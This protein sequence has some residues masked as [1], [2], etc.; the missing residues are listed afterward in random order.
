[1]ILV[2][3]TAAQAPAQNPPYTWSP[4][5][6]PLANTVNGVTYFY[7]PAIN[8]WTVATGG[9][10]AVTT[11]GLGLTITGAFTKVAIPIQSPGPAAGGG[12][13]Q[14]VP[15]SLYWDNTLGELFIYYDDGTTAQWV[16]TTG[17]GT[18]PIPPGLGISQTSGFTKISVPI[19]SPGP[20]AGTGAN[21]AEPGALYWDDSLGEL[22]IYYDDGTTAQWVSTTGGSSV[23]SAGYGM[24]LESN[25]YKPAIPALSA[26][27]TTGTAP[28]EAPDGSMY[29][30][31]GLG[32][33]F[34]RYNDGFTTQWV[35]I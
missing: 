18:P 25:S 12:Q 5:S 34:Y 9:G 26:P 10:G 21:Q 11:P 16:S 32:A 1:M 22:F 28:L 23:P 2:F 30:D 29:Y 8:Q 35:Q 4:T 27:P 24:V 15:G 6:T 17:G 31:T 33:M 13:Y 14:A 20:S 7:D 19:Q 3:P